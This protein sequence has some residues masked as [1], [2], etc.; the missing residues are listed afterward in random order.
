MFDRVNFHLGML[1]HAGYDV[2]LLSRPSFKNPLCY[3]EK[4]LWVENNLGEEWVEKFI[5]AP[6]KSLLI[7]DYLID[8]KPWD[9]FQ[10]KQFLIGSDEYPDWYTIL[11]ELT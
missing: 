5:L 2:W 10:G 1:E 6:D 9:D 3:T 4:R 11:D 7:G 8:D